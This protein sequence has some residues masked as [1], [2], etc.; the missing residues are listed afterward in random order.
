[1][2]LGLDLL[3][4]LAPFMRFG[5]D[6]VRLYASPPSGA[7]TNNLFV[8]SEPMGLMSIALQQQRRRAS[9]PETI[10]LFLDTGMGVGTFATAHAG[11]TPPGGWSVE[12]WTNGQGR[13]SVRV[14]HDHLA[15]SSVDNRTC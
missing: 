12:Q 4:R 11:L 2:I 6:D 5:D 3:R 15:F 1:M 10:R 13:R 9:G 8:Q 7:C 14:G